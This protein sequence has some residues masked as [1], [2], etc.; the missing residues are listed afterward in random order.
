MGSCVRG[1]NT[2]VGSDAV[3][4]L[5]RALFDSKLASARPLHVD[6]CFNA[7]GDDLGGGRQSTR[8]GAQVDR[9]HVM[10]PYRP[11]LV[12]HLETVVIV[13]HN[14]VREA[15]F[16]FC[17]PNIQRCDQKAHASFCSMPRDLAGSRVVSSRALFRSSYLDKNK[18]ETLLVPHVTTFEGKSKD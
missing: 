14:M 5:G 8:V 15:L 1:C 18:G 13:L 17:P 9:E 11:L 6:H 4:M 10:C 3:A 2:Q 16:S 7:I 12:L